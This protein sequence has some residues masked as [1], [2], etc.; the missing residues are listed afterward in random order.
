MN[1]IILRVS[2]RKADYLIAVAVVLFGLLFSIVYTTL[3]DTAST[4]VTVG[5]ASPTLTVTLD[6]TTIT[7]TENTFVWASSTVTVTDGN[8]CSEITSVRAQLAYVNPATTPANGAECSYAAN[9]CYL[10]TTKPAPAVGTCLATTTGNTCTGGTDTSAQYECGFPVWYDAT[11]TDA[12]SPGL[13]GSY[14][15]VTATT[16]D[17]T[18]TVAATNTTQ[19]VD[20]ATLNSLDVTGPIAYGS[21]SPSSNTGA[22]NQSVTHTNTGNTAIDNEIS[23]DVMCTNYSTCTAGK[24]LLPGQQ[25][26]GTSNVTYASLTSTLIAT[27][28]PATIELALATSTAPTTAITTITYC[29][30][31]VPAAQASGA[32]TGQNTLTAVAD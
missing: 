9:T 11:P 17:G 13:T 15:Y 31:A 10:P 28:T 22:T 26:F 4:T 18:A 2:E 29:G 6:R 8:G 1:K 19:T 25:K 14:W 21:V 7:L 27:T 3:A 12:S 23:G 16:T 32:Y 24:I 20:V 30:I 5:N